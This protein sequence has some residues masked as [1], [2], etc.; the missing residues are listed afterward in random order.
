MRKLWV[1]VA[2]LGVSCGPSYT[3][4]HRYPAPVVGGAGGPEGGV[5]VEESYLEV[6]DAYGESVPDIWFFIAALSPHGTWLD[7]PELGWV[8]LPNQ[9]DY[10]PYGDGYWLA[11]DQGVTWVALDEI[12]WAVTH[13]GRWH[14][15]D[16]WVWLPD[17]DWGP[18]WV[19]W[20]EVGKWIGWAPLSRDGTPHRAWRGWRFVHRDHLFARNLKDHLQPL[21]MNEKLYGES[22]TIGRRGRTKDG[23]SFPV[24]P[25]LRPDEASNDTSALPPNQGRLNAEEQRE[26]IRRANEWRTKGEGREK[27]ERFKPGARKEKAEQERQE[28]ERN[29]KAEKERQERERNDKAERDRQEHERASQ[30]ERERKERERNEKAEKERQ[31]RERNE[32]AARDRQEHERAAQAERERKERERN[33]QAERERLERE[34]NEKAADPAPARERGSKIKRPGQTK[35]QDAPQEGEESEDPDQ[36]D[37]EDEAACPPGQDCAPKRVKGLQRGRTR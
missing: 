25:A 15:R 4:N 17:L 9:Q 23:F 37:D 1:L 33:E 18:A 27:E 12:G 24:G 19:E 3:V 10:F 16:R 22:S 5:E 7:D 14:Y 30:A 11:T 29:E 21:P 8:F 34:R 6:D 2:L 31:E 36:A 20:R 28:R 35:G 13:Y 32:K 26:A